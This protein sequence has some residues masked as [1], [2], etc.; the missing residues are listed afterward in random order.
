[1]TKLEPIIG[2][3]DVEKS[4]DWYQ[5]ILNLQSSHGGD[6]FEMLVNKN[7]EIILC[8]HSWEEHGHPTL[9]EPENNGNGL[10]LYF[11]IEDLE[12]VWKNA[13]RLNAKIDYDPRLNEN[14]GKEEF[15]LWDLDGYYLIISK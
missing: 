12:K 9:L 4:A 10:I 6:S 2:V 14:S 13:I 15:A 1:M 7:S 3:Q 8:L 11:K 5:N